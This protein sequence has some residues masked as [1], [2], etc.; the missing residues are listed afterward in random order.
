MFGFRFLGK[1]HVPH[2]KNTAGSV[3][4][5]MLPPKE[6]L[7]PVSQHIGSPATVTVKVGDEVKVCQLIA[8]ASGNVSASVHSSVSGKVI[9]DSHLL[10]D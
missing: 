1:T 6:V 7:L 5:K 10:I 9:S 3:P 2:C 4:V 8:E